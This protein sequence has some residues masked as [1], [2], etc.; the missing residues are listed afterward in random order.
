MT[1]VITCNAPGQT[2]A[3]RRP[4]DRRIRIRVF[5]W[6]LVKH[7][8]GD[9]T[10]DREFYQQMRASFEAIPKAPP[11]LRQHQEDGFLYGKIM[12]IGADDVG[13]YADAELSDEAYGWWLA[14]RI[15]DWSPGLIVETTNKHTG[16]KML[17]VLRELSFVSKG[18]LDNVENKSPAY[19]LAEYLGDTPEEGEMIEEEKEMQGG[20][21]DVEALAELRGD[22]EEFKAEVKAGLAGIQEFIAGLKGEEPEGE[23]ADVDPAAV[24]DIDMEED[25]KY[26]MADKALAKRLATAEAKIKAAEDRAARAEAATKL[27]GLTMSDKERGNLLQLACDKPEAFTAAVGA[28]KATVKQMADQTPK[29]KEVGGYSQYFNEAGNVGNVEAG[30]A[31]RI[32]V[33]EAVKASKKAGASRLIAM[34]DAAKGA[35]INLSDEGQSAILSDVLNEI[36]G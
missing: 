14:G 26:S 23:M 33:A 12:D 34:K 17:N 13:I 35:R 31:L 8:M 27:E 2:E 4:E 6:G 10:V 18:H 3:L 7:P 22:F 16:E 9:F 32:K 1:T 15:A 29:P 5:S 25:D 19:S 36:Y 28:I 20:V 30:N 11:I 21:V 24:E